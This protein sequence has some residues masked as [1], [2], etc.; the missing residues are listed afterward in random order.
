MVSACGRSTVHPNTCPSCNVADGQRCER[1]PGTKET[2]IGHQSRWPR[3]HDVRSRSMTTSHT[4]T[5]A[6]VAMY[7]VP[8]PEELE[9]QLLEIRATLA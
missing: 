2:G 5:V 7:S 9:R 3:A 1:P 6:M 8:L 4:A